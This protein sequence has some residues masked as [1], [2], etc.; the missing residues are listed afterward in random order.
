[1][2]SSIVSAKYDFNLMIVSSSPELSFSL[3]HRDLIHRNLVHRTQGY[4]PI[5]GGYFIVG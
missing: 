2:A 1:M 3:I 4:N 5:P